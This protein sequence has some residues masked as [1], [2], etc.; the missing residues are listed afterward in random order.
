MPLEAQCSVIQRVPVVHA[1][2]ANSFLAESYTDEVSLRI[3][4]VDT[5]IVGHF[6]PWIIQPIWLAEQGLVDAEAEVVH[7]A[8]QPIATG[9]LQFQTGSFHW[10]VSQDRLIVQSDAL[11][12]TAAPIIDIIDRLPH[13]PVSAVG[14][15]FNYLTTAPAWDGGH[16]VLGNVSAD[17]LAAVGDIVSQSWQVELALRQGVVAKILVRIDATNVIVSF[18]FHRSI[19]AP[20]LAKAALRN[21]DDDYQ[22]SRRLLVDVLAVEVEE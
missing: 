3:H 5:V 22:T 19:N 2:R 7:V 21:F 12:N 9:V 14:N 6:N 10:K 20:D 1:R 16:P 13:T 18:N 15:N 8:F 11:V 17:Q 4:G